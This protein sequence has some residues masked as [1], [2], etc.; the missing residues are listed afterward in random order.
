M[1]CAASVRALYHQTVVLIEVIWYVNHIGLIL[2]HGDLDSASLDM[3]VL[4]QYTFGFMATLN[5]DFRNN[6][7]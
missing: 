7:F 5:M 6:H 3:T 2:V 1:L 4:I